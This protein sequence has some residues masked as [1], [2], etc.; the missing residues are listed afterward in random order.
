[1]KT[2]CDDTDVIDNTYAVINPT[3]VVVEDEYVEWSNMLLLDISG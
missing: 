2:E 3:I 1:M